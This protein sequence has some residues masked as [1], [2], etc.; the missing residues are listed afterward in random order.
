MPTT[1]AL[2][3]LTRIAA[4]TA[5]CPLAT[6]AAAD[7]HEYS[8]VVDPDLDRLRVRAAFSADVGSIRVRSRSAARYLVEATPCEGDARL[9]ASDRRMRL[10]ADVRCI[11]YVVD[12]GAA[13]AA[14]R[15]N[16]NLG[17]DTILVSPSRWLWRPELDAET[18]IRV[19]F[20]LPD[21][22]D[23]AVPWQPIDGSRTDYLLA[24]SPESAN[25][26]AV[27]GRFTYHELDVPGATVRVALPETRPAIDEAKT[28]AWLE[29]TA[30]DVSLTYGRF[31]NPSPF[32]VVL[33]MG[34]SRWSRSA[35]PFGRVIRDGG[36]AIELFVDQQ[37]PREDYMGDW[38]ATHEFS[39]LMLP[40]VGSRYKWIS[41][42]FAQYYQ[43][44]LLA[45]SGT[46]DDE[47]A[48]AKIHA[49]LSRGAASR[50]ELSPNEAAARGV[51]GA[52]MKVYWSGAAIALL[53]D[54]EL[55]KRSGGRE[56]LDDVL[57]RLQRCCLP[58]DRT[59]SG[60]E[61]FMHLDTLIDEP[62]FMPLYQRHADTT[63]FPDTSAVFERLGIDVDGGDVRFDDDAE[64]AGLRKTITRIDA[65]TARWRQQLAAD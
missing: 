64:L 26:P 34:S 9:L 2:R 8:V 13:A 4:F 65:E 33:P 54:V 7:V 22:V 44:V 29:A 19:R 20:E 16:R 50:P 38:T 59:W 47:M 49:G 45:R 18:R 52:R 17:N 56:S 46:Y 42:G 27:F 37:K 51:R 35:V 6:T 15:R 30:T 31:P 23:V 10:P 43:N 12:L 55:R 40:Y 14:E 53:A 57:S 25:A 28:L 63:G 32:V 61:L 62:L 21:G 60:P 3:Q 11:D 5:L 1:S 24:A 36:E 41:E 58:S 39:H 48:W